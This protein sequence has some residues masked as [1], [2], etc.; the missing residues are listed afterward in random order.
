[1]IFVI[2]FVKGVM[3]LSVFLLN[4]FRLIFLIGNLIMF[5]VMVILF[6]VEKGVGLR[7]DW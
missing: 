6:F 1:M 4:L 7:N 5:S 3:V 2:D